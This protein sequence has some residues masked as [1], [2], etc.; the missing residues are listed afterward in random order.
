MTNPNTGT[1]KQDI[2]VIRRDLSLAME[3]LK[4]LNTSLSD[5]RRIDIETQSLVTH[6]VSKTSLIGVVTG[7]TLFAAAISFLGILMV[8]TK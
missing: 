1:M 8:L 6:L 5:L 4:K 2:V 3:E 7:F